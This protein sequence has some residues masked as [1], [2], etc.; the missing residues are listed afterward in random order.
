ME[1]LIVKLGNFETNGGFILKSNNKTIHVFGGLPDEVVKIR[2]Y[3]KKGGYFLGEITDVIKPSKYRVLPKEDHFLSC[4]PLQIL[5]ESFEGDIKREIIYKLLKKYNLNIESFD[6][7]SDNSFYN[8]R[9]KM[10]FNFL[11]NEIALSFFKRGSHKDKIKVEF[12]VLALNSINKNL[13]EFLNY[14]KQNNFHPLD[15]KSVIFRSNRLGEVTISLFIKKE[16]EIKKDFN[17]DHIKSFKIYYSNPLSPA[18]VKTKLLYSIGDDYLEEDIL[19]KKIRYSSTSFFQVNINMFE[20]ALKDI[21]EFLSD[22]E[23]LYDFYSGVGT[24]GIALKNK[25]LYFIENDSENQKF[26]KLNCEL[27]SLEN[28]KII[29]EKAQDFIKNINPNSISIFDPPREGLNKK[30]VNY[31]LDNRIKRIIYLSCNPDTQLRD[32]SILKEKYTI[33]FFKCYNFFPRTPHVESLIVL[34][35]K[36]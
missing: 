1:E 13:D 24:I 32:V 34:D 4:S 17:L 9:N 35:K 16:L 22:E 27:N 12:C 14:L 8:Y 11:N 19:G 23:T 21:R 28:Y 18:S 5:I 10:E 33:R 25:N 20:R 6:I 7:E 15:L 29:N 36:V 3:Q 31:L 30:I 26:L 2:I